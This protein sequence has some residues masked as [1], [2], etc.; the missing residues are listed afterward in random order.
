MDK[1]VRTGCATCRKRR[2]KCDERKPTCAR[3]EAA[4]FVC[5][6]YPTPRRAPSAASGSPTPSGSTRSPKRSPPLEDSPFSGL[7]WRPTSW[8]QEQ[9]PLYHHFVTTTVV[10][11]FRID[12]VTFWRDE[13]AQMSVGFDLVYEALLAVGALH[14]ASLLNCQNKDGPEAARSRVLGLHAY[15]NALRM[16]PNHLNQTALRESVA[17]QAVLILLTFCEVRSKHFES[18]L[19]KDQLTQ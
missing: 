6:G 19:S 1:R 8:R 9:L 7:S 4:N 5:E 15:G 10:R 14:R 3:C 12:H 2:I 18:P 16:L 11:F 17:V 13:V